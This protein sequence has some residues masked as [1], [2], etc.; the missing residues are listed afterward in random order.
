MHFAC[1]LQA[2]GEAAVIEMRA[3]AQASAIRTIAEALNGEHSSE[4][5]KLAVAREVSTGF[6]GFNQCNRCRHRISVQHLL[7]KH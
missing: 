1:V 6:L 3:K 7:T 4:A 5:A 2:T